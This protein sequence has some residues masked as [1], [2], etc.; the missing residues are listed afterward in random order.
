MV[1][2]KNGDLEMTVGL[3]RAHVRIS[4]M[5]GLRESVASVLPHMELSSIAAPLLF[6]IYE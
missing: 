1:G 6:F 3:A 4:D 2:S 5:D